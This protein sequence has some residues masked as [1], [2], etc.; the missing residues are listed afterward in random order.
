MSGGHFDY[1][2]YRI[3]DIVYDIEKLI[4]FNQDSNHFSQDTIKKF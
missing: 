3:D 1:N 4:K 2:Q